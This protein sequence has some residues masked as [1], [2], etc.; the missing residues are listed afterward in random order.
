MQDGN[1]FQ[2]KKNSLYQ[3]MHLHIFCNEATMFFNGIGVQKTNK[4]NSLYYQI[5]FDVECA[6]EVPGV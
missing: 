6:F 4:K 3:F 1:I 5:S 2:V